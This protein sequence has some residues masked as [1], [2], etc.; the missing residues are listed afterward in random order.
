MS[1]KFKKI[2]VGFDNSPSSKIAIEKSVDTAS[3]FDS[4]I[5]AV[6]VTDNEKD[7]EIDEN[8]KYIIE[9]SERRKRPIEFIVKTGR[10]YKEINTL[11]REIGADLIFLGTH[12][13][14][15]WQPFWIG[16]TAF[17]IVSASNCP[18][19]TISE[20]TKKVDLQDILLPLADSIE[21]RQKVP[22]AAVLAKAFNA[23]VHIL[24]V[25]SDKDKATQNRLNIYARQTEKYLDERNIRWTLHESLGMKVPEACINY[26]KEVRAGLILIMTETESS[27]VFMGSY[28]Q[29]L[30]NESH[31]PVMSIHSRDLFVAGDVGY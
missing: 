19:I 22:Y 28:A 9:L 20:T 23:T 10:A 17:R 11:E 13:K 18:V 2:L 12:G 25:S 4:E 16:S 21:S 30:I 6:Y 1:I 31:V 3:L 26:S 7:P 29:Q 15:G 24:K 27:G 8:K 5:T 14:Q